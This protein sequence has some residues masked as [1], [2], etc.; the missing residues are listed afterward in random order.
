MV[1]ENCASSPASFL[2]GSLIDITLAV[3]LEKLRSREYRPT[4]ADVTAETCDKALSPSAVGHSRVPSRVRCREL[5]H[6][7]M[8]DAQHA[9]SPPPGL[10]YIIRML[11]PPLVS[12]F[13]TSLH[14]IFR[15]FDHCFQVC[16]LSDLI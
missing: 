8:I 14:L 13:R 2:R 6:G 10:E 15:Q 12:A 1:L 11:H 16:D 3:A 5:A 7:K 9:Y 4:S